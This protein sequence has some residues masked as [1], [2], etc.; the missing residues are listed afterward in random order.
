MN[1]E[2]CFVISLSWT[3]KL[4]WILYDYIICFAVYNNMKFCTQTHS[5]MVEYDEI[6]YSV[7]IVSLFLVTYGAY[8]EFVDDFY[9]IKCIPMVNI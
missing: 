1:N 2:M 3:N 8:C 4:D 5:Y 9:A 7:N 6:A